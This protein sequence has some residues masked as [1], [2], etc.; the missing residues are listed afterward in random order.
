MGKNLEELSSLVG[1]LRLEKRELEQRARI[2][3][4]SLAA[5]THHEE[6]L[7]CDEVTGRCNVAAHTCLALLAETDV[8]MHDT[9]QTADSTSPSRSR[10]AVLLRRLW[11]RGKVTAAAES[12][13]ASGDAAGLT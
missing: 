8:G 4:S 9:L 2:L 11:W 1:R 5:N 13:S 3:E 10:C 7:H 6:R 12:S